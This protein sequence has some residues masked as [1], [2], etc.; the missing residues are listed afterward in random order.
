MGVSAEVSQ[1]AG[2]SGLDGCANLFLFWRDYGKQGVNSS[3]TFPI[4]SSYTYIFVAAIEQELYT[5]LIVGL[6]NIVIS[7]Y[8]Y[9]IVVKKMYINEPA[10]PAPLT[11]SAPLKTAIV[12]G[13]AGTLL[14]GLYPDP[15]INWAVDATLMFSNAGTPAMP[16]GG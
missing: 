12:I 11:V 16:V 8:Y 10:D 2:V 5:L 6:I 13:I 7:A 1:I 9:L 4:L 15:F 3:Y 14:L